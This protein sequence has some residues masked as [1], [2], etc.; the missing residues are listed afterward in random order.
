M[1][2]THQHPR[3]A[4][5]MSSR[6]F[7]GACVF[8]SLAFAASQP[9]AAQAPVVNDGSSITWPTYAEALEREQITIESVPLGDRT[10]RVELQRFEPFTRDARLVVV[11]S[12]GQREMPRPEVAVFSGKVTGDDTSSAFISLSPFGAY[13]FIVASGATHV[14][15][16][17][18]F[19]S[20]EAVHVASLQSLPVGNEP[21]R[22]YADESY[23]IGPVAP[24]GATNRGTPPCRTAVLA[25]ET[26]Y[27]YTA[28]L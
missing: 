16:T 28:N 4:P 7:G 1:F 19:G 15:S 5:I 18:S 23:V 9:S 13:G 8:A 22:C 21:Y 17:G 25:I 10:V 12:D 14:I 20:A 6:F 27:E 24:P 2:R 3:G 26:D 11:G